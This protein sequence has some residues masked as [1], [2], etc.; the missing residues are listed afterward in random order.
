MND[1]DKQ[2]AELKGSGTLA[3]LAKSPAYRAAVPEAIPIVESQ[4]SWST[5]DAK[6]LEL[7]DEMVVDTDFRLSYNSRSGAWTA[8]I[9]RIS[10]CQAVGETRAEAIC[11]VYI[12]W[13]AYL[14]GA[15]P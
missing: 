9:G 11:K 13:M 15:R 12:A 4:V 2:I 3:F 10:P 6:A 5:S 7:V 14:R 1:L 8:E